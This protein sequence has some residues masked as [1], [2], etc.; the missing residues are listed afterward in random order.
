[1]EGIL[2]VRK[3]NKQRIGYCFR[4]STVTCR[5]EYSLLFE[6]KLEGINIVSFLTVAAGFVLKKSIADIIKE[7]GINEKTVFKYCK[8]LRKS[9][10]NKIDAENIVIGGSGREVEIDETHLFRR[11]YHRGRELRF[12]SIWIFGCFERITKKYTFKGSL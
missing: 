12:E 8:I 9:C 3:T 2:K 6:S 4:C 1:L 5:R 10:T 7:S 11:K